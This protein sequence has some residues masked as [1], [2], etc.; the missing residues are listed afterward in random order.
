MAEV[1]HFAI[2]ADDPE[3]ARR[4]YERVFGWTFQASGPPGFYHIT[5]GSRGGAIPGALQQRRELVP[6][7]AVHGFECTIAV[8]DLDAVA[9]AVAAAGGRIVTEKTAI[10]G[11]GELLFFE[12]S[13][14]NVAG[15][16]RYAPGAR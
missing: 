12:D 2:N 4:F 6:G 15:A 9:A 1:S 14:G 8:D 5:T 10:P 7:R 3:R 11:V 13:E 16:M